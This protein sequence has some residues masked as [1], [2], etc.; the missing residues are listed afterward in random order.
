M[1]LKLVLPLSQSMD[2]FRFSPSQAFSTLVLD[3]KKI[4]KDWQHKTDISLFIM[5]PTIITCNLFYLKSNYFVDIIGQRWKCLTLTKSKS[6]YI[7]GRRYIRLSLKSNGYRLAL[8]AVLILPWVDHSVFCRLSRDWL[9]RP[10]AIQH[11]G[12]ARGMPLYAKAYPR[13]R[14]KYK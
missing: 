9:S 14:E 10:G 12:G 8:H 4:H 2:I 7:L 1:Q 6:C 3:D 13:F 5:K 11:R